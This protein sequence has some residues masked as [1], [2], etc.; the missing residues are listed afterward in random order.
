MELSQTKRAQIVA[1]CECGMKQVDVS[2]QLGVSKQVVSLTIRR[3][4]ETK[5][6][7]SKS[8]SGRPRK[9]TP[10][11]DRMIRRLAVANPSVSSKAIASSLPTPVSSRLVRRRLHDE[12]DLKSYR[13]AKKPLL[14]RKNIADR[15]KFCQKFKEWTGEMWEQVLFSDEC[16]FRQF[17]NSGALHVRRPKGSR[18][19]Q[20]YIV[21]MVKHS[22]S[23]MIWGSF[24]SSGR[25][26][27]WFLPPNTTMRSENYLNVLKER[28]QPMMNIR[29]TKIFMHDGA[30]CHQAVLVKRW[31]ASQGIEI[32]SPWPGNS[33]ELNPLENLWHIM[34]AKVA[35]HRPTS[36]ENLKEV[37]EGVWCT[38]ITPELCQKL[39]HSMPKRINDV[40]NNKGQSIKY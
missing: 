23:V 9:T 16:M 7:Q 21:P 40:L 32:L 26:N 34:K 12:F 19:Q 38:E 35:A 6:F 4:K 27:L 18:F 8:R 25:G 33:P 39:V 17:P 10:A 11:T 13:P 20:R 3:F 31:L 5:S 14:S 28:L 36:F 22:S 1:L 15:L 2:K 29:G 30:P 24:A 37:I